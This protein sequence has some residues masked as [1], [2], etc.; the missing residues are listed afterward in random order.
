MKNNEF[1]GKLRKG[2]NFAA[3]KNHDDRISTNLFLASSLVQ[4]FSSVGA[5]PLSTSGVCFF[6]VPSPLSFGSFAFC[7]RHFLLLGHV[8]NR[9]DTQQA[10]LRH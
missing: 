7:R 6:R 4:P 1:C 2:A 8:Q 10:M 5:F 3:A 9:I